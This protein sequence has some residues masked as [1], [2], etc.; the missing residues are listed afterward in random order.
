M[1]EEQKEEVVKALRERL[2]EHNENRKVT[3]KEAADGCDT[4][5]KG[6]RDLEA[7][8]LKKI[9]EGFAKV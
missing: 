3:Q 7:G 8:L 5:V 2:D 1:A 6:V 4:L 9:E